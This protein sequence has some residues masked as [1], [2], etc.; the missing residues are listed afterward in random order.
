MTSTTTGRIKPGQVTTPAGR[1]PRSAG[2]V[3]ACKRALQ[4]FSA[5]LVDRALASALGGNEAALVAV[6]GLYSAAL[7]AATAE[8]AHSAAKRKR[9]PSTS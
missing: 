9:T 7:Q 3:K 8:A 5:E 6:L 4:P 2:L 1:L